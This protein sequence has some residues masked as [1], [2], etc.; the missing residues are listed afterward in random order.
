MAPRQFIVARKHVLG[1][2]FNRGSDSFIRIPAYP[3]MY[4][5][6]AVLTN[7]AERKNII[8][9]LSALSLYKY[10][11]PCLQVRVTFRGR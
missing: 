2:H 6:K 8:E 5:F 9:K 4:S 1:G 7:T 3:N 11:L 10:T